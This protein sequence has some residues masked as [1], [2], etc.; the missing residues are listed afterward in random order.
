LGA[1]LA[2]RVLSVGELR[3]RFPFELVLIIGSALVI[4][5]V[6]DSS[7]AETH[8]MVYTPGRYRLL[9]FVRFGLPVSITYSVVVI[10]LLAFSYPFA[11]R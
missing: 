6:L 5:R 2:S 1:L 9:D 11:P 8:L 10:V 7:G 3:R 4:A